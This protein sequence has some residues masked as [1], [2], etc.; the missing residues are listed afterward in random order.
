MKKQRGL[1][2]LKIAATY[3]GTIVGAGFATGQETLV[4][5]SRFGAW[6]LLGLGVVTGLF[7][8]FGYIIMALGRRFNARSHLEV[9]RFANGR[10]IGGAVDAI[11]LFFLFGAL[12]AMI[13]GTG[14]L[15]AQQYRLP[16]M[17][18]NLLMAALT[19]FTVLAGFRG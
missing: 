5:F 2:P 17:T 14:A 12:C 11:I 16:A 19:V 13:A 10:F 3:I 4:F 15:I 1:S 18:G 6:G 9:I 8:A 7:I